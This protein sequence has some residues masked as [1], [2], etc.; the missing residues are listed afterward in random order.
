MI[1]LLAGLSCEQLLMIADREV[2]GKLFLDCLEL[3]DLVYES[4][5][6]LLVKILIT[7]YGLF[8]ALKL[9]IELGFLRL[10]LLIF[11]LQIRNFSLCELEINHQVAY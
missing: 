9:R 4:V 1:A 8:E 10:Q 5:D 7:H 2:G 6:L 3:P 11:L